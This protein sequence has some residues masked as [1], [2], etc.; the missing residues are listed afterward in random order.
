MLYNTTEIWLEMEIFSK[1]LKELRTAAGYTQQQMA[2]ILNIRQQ[3]Y[4]RYEN[5]TGEPNLS[6]VAAIS[7]ILDVSCD[8]LLG[9]SEF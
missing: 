8:Y 1:R 4:A 3:S 2:D 9:T 6:T 7:K 5:N